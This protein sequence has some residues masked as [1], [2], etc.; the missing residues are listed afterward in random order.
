[1]LN[2]LYNQV[3][4]EVHTLV[5]LSNKCQKQLETLLEVRTFEQ[6]TQQVTSDVISNKAL[7]SVHQQLPSLFQ[8]KLWFS[9]EGEK[10][11]APLDALT[12]SVAKITEMRES[13]RQFLEE[14]VVKYFYKCPLNHCLMSIH[15]VTNESLCFQQQQRHG[16]QLV[17]DSPESLPDSLVLDFKQHLG[18][19][20][21]RVERRRAQLDILANLYEFYDSVSN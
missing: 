4:E 10:Q 19:F 18:S 9:V 11:L 21:S 12:L 2:A 20:L 1:M 14:S 13:L 5:I 6:Q 17:N 15:Q 8:I 7:C 16:L 3:D